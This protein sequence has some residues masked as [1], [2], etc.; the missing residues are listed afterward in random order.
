MGEL[1]DQLVDSNKEV[2]LT[3]LTRLRKQTLKNFDISIYQEQLVPLIKSQDKEIK[4]L[5]LKVLKNSLKSL[6]YNRGLSLSKDFES[7]KRV[8][9]MIV[10]I[11][12]IALSDRMALIRKDAIYGIDDIVRHFVKSGDVAQVLGDQALNLLAD[13]IADT[14]IDLDENGEPVA[15]KGTLTVAERVYSVIG[16]YRAKKTDFT[17]VFHALIPALE[18]MH[19]YISNQSLDALYGRKLVER[20]EE[21]FELLLALRNASLPKSSFPDTYPN[22]VV[23]LICFCNDHKFHTIS[24]STIY[25]IRKQ[26]CRKSYLKDLVETLGVDDYREVKDAVLYMLSQMLDEDIHKGISIDYFIP[27]IKEALIKSEIELNELPEALKNK[28]TSTLPA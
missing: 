4:C 27:Q 24:D 13:H 11:Y 5:L 3:A 28:L 18:R 8:V 19:F 23:E 15:Q 1:K 14:G 10:K 16:E 21:V 17:P 20:I 12:L 2:C 22:Y 9:T 6:P 26:L 7:N 25:F